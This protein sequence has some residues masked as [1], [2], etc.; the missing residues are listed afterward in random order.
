MCG[1][2]PVKV[3]RNQ[4]I[5][6]STISYSFRL[7]AITATNVSSF[8][9][10]NNEV[11]VRREIKHLLNFTKHSS[12]RIVTIVTIGVLTIHAMDHW[13]ALNIGFKAKGLAT[14]AMCLHLIGKKRLNLAHCHLHRINHCLLKR[15][16][17]RQEIDHPHRARFA[18][19]Q[20]KC[21]LCGSRQTIACPHVVVEN[22]ANMDIIRQ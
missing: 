15:A 8:I 17:I 11:N 21:L 12:K 22:F 1:C 14:I 2:C 18:N 5:P 10:Y 3:V 20:I 7:S 16:V 19:V 9:I 13:T 6:D 4:R